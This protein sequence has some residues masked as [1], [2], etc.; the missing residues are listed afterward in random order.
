MIGWESIFNHII[1]IHTEKT[2]KGETSKRL[3]S[4]KVGRKQVAKIKMGKDLAEARYFL[5]EDKMITILR[6]VEASNRARH[7]RQVLK[8]IILS[9]CAGVLASGAVMLAYKLLSLIIA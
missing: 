3:T 7:K 9:F 2:R 4:R 5:A 1:M 8:M 6:L